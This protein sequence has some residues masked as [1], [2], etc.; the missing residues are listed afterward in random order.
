MELLLPPI[1][2][3]LPL[4]VLALVPWTF[5]AVAELFEAV[6]PGRAPPGPRAWPAWSL[7]GVYAGLFVYLAEATSAA[8][9]SSSSALV[10]LLGWLVIG[11]LLFCGM[12]VREFRL[13]MLRRDDEFPGRSD[14][15]AWIFALTI[16]A[17]AGVWMFRS[18]R[19]ARWPAIA[20]AGP[21]PRPSRG[22]RDGGRG[23]MRGDL[24]DFQVSISEI[25]FATV[26]LVP[27]LFFAV[28]ALFE[29]FPK[30]GLRQVAGLVAAVGWALGLSS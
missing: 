27:W 20:P 13:L 30:I 16:L 29:D 4:V 23:A 26:V 11:P 14:K 6:P 7:L 22:R 2:A 28:S 12:W 17:P 10:P 24:H 21:S 19:M 18:F 8:R 15:L 3:L 25:P 5:F 9:S 1:L